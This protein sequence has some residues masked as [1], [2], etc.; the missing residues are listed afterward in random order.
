[1][2]GRSLAQGWGEDNPWRRRFGKVIADYGIA[3]VPL[4]LFRLQGALG[5]SPQETWF[6]ACVLSYKWDERDPYPSLSEISKLS[7]V[8]PSTL[9]EYKSSLVKKGLLRIKERHLP[10]GR[11][12]SHAYDFTPL[13][14][15]IEK[16]I[17]TIEASYGTE[18]QVREERLVAGGG[19]TCRP[20]EDEYEEEKNKK[21]PASLKAGSNPLPLHLGDGR[22][23]LG[24][25]A[26]A[27][28]QTWTCRE[29]G[30]E[31]LSVTEATEGLCSECYFRRWKG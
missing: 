26:F 25:G 4:L 18:E 27:A 21:K 6:I 28:S 12:L 22:G 16:L 7:G 30:K 8:P 29:C 10:D 1:M 31:S 20:E 3:A 2:L 15:R 5:L 11:S 19:A 24:G 13:F 14:R 23:L 9:R 17:E